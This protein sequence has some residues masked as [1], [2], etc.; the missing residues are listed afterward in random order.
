MINDSLDNVYARIRAEE[1]E[2]L[3]RRI[4]DAFFR[5]PRLKELDEERAKLFS[6]LG[7]RKITAEAGKLRLEEIAREE[8]DILLS[9]GL[10]E[11][12]LRLH[13]RC[14]L[15]HDTGYVGP[16]NRPCACRLLNRE[17][18]RGLA[19]GVNERET[20]AHFSSS[21][22]PTPEQKKRTLNARA[23]CETYAKSLPAPEKPNLLLLGMP[24]LGKSFLGNAIAYEALSRGVDAE[25]VTAYAFVQTVLRDIRERT[26]KAQRYQTVPLLVLDDL[27][28]EPNIPNVSFEWLFA[29]INERT[30]A[31]RATVCSS[32][33]TLK[34]LSEIY[35]E[36]FMSR[37]CD[38][39]TTQVLM[40]TGE[41]LRT[42]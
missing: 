30:I 16:N 41:N 6:D 18:L 20:F 3:S 8:W 34:Q 1:R 36:R 5:A 13:E 22:F 15:C 29:V 32:N 24:G 39:N 31:G 33:C 17:R 25:R 10:A 35:D 42:I 2:A 38:R 21:I 27:G 12:T 40:L 7:A 11:D 14:E 4:D 9:L 28:S 19:E 26:E 37:L 23:I